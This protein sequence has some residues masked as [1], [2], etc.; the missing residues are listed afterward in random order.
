[1]TQRSH[2][3]SGLTFDPALAAKTVSSFGHNGAIGAR[4]IAHGEDWVELALDY[5]AELVGDEETGVLAS[6][7]IIA[8]MDMATSLATWVRRGRFEP[9]A[10]LDLRIDYLR[11]AVP[12]RTVIGHGECYRLTRRIAFVRGI[13]HDGDPE[14]PIAHVAGTFMMTDAA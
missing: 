6:G 11:A 2:F 4:Y 7:P 9:Q 5:R 10:T 3:N 14:D 1:M 13:A 8:L 12:E